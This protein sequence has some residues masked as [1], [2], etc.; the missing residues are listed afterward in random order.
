LIWIN[1]PPASSEKV[2]AASE[3]SHGFTS[4]IARNSALMNKAML[5]ALSWLLPA[6]A[7]AL[8]PSAERGHAFVR[9]HCARCHAIDRVSESPL[10]EAPPFRN[11]HLRYPV[12]TLEEALAEGIVTGHPS[13]PE[14]QLDPGQIADVIAFFRTLE[15]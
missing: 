1:A 15:R 9:A 2:A 12:E 4:K 7:A 5:I 13:M 8:E 6:G 3:T 10:K 11:L 14:F